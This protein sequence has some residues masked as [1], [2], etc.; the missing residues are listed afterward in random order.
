MAKYI[1][2]EIVAG[3][4]SIMG[5]IMGLGTEEPA[6]NCAAWGVF[7]LCLVL[8]PIYLKRNAKPGEPA[9]R[10]MIVSTI[11]FVQWAYALGGAFALAGLHRPWLGSVLLGCWT[12]VAGLIPAP[13]EGDK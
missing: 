4:V 10:N 1:P 5:V 8:T 11:S 6:R 9:R 2:G 3:Y 13:Y 7:L 12:M